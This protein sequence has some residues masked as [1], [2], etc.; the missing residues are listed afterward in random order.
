MKMPFTVKDIV[1]LTKARANFTDL[2]EEIHGNQGEKIITKNGEGCV[3]LID[4]D[5]L[6]Y[7]H[8]LEREHIYIGLLKE[9]IQGINDIERKKTISLRQFKKRHGR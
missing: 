6:D 7:Y 2:C 1:P 4:A 5:L 9:A 3:A 8:R